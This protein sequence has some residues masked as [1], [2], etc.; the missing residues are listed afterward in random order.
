MKS[1]G[2]LLSLF[3]ICFFSLTIFAQTFHKIEGWPDSTNTKIQ[4]YLESSKAV[5]DRKVAVFDCDGTILGQSPY[6]LS[7]EVMCNYAKNN[8]VGK[9]DLLSKNAVEHMYKYVNGKGNPMQPLETIL[10]LSGISPQEAENIG[11]KL[12]QE[13]KYADKVFPQ[14]KQLIANLKEYGFEVWAV[15]GAQEVVYQKIC[16]DVFGIPRTRVIGAKTVIA[17]GKIT[18]QFVPPLPE[19][20]GKKH[21]IETFIKAQPMFVVGNSRGDLDMLL[22]SKGMRIVVN[23]DST[24]KATD[25]IL[26]NQTLENYCQEHG[27]T[28]VKCKDQR[29]AG[30]TYDC[31][32]FGIE[33]NPAN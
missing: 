3:L 4:Q 22:Y 7:N 11:W 17:N 29:P 21:V 6:Y 13:K 20:A 8:C 19:R 26:K 14:M 25:P 30:V 1:K 31:A 5:Q 10:T 15:T 16:S 27:F 28:I 33:T 23:P 2:I 24:E 32:D 9:D 18:N 12:F